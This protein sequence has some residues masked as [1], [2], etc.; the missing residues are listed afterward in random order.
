M[1]QGS[2]LANIPSGQ[3]DPLA[4]L[5]DIHLPAP[6]S[7]FPIAP[8]WWVLALA[9]LL[10]LYFTI[11]WAW[12]FWRSNQY[13][14]VGVK[15]LNEIFSQ[16]QYDEDHKR[17]LSSYSSLLK[18]IAL[19]VYPREKVASLTG[20][21]WVAFLDQSY[22]NRG[23]SVGVGQVLMYGGYESETSFDAENLHKLGLE[24]VKRHKAGWADE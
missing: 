2:P 13:R 24:W 1:G 18:R 20:E 19:T 7:E 16:F 21:E 6:I 14:R 12:K 5:R 4:E 11:R 23:F 22:R 9:A 17:Y 8:G 15:Q 10:L 3:M